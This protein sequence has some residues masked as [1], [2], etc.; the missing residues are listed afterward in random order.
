MCSTATP[1]LGY[2][3]FDQD[4]P[5]PLPSLNQEGFFGPLFGLTFKDPISNKKLVRAIYIA[6]YF[7]TF[8]YEPS[9]NTAICKK[10]NQSLFTPPSYTGQD[11]ASRRYPIART[12]DRTN[13]RDATHTS[14]MI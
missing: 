7:N 13:Q 2:Q 14:G 1:N 6:E 10:L 12:D 4:Y 3:I 9:F 8:G 5:A 11:N